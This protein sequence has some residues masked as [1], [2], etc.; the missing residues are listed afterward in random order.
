[1]HRAEL[2]WLIGVWPDLETKAV[3]V[4]R[5]LTREKIFM[6][7]TMDL[8]FMTGADSERFDEIVLDIEVS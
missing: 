7:L 5:R 6:V 1:M 8:D 3:A 4:P 2:L